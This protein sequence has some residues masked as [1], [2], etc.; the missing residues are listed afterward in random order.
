MSRLAALLSLTAAMACSSREALEQA[1]QP[2]YGGKPDADDRAVVAVVNFAGGQCSGTLIARRLV[3]TARHCV[4]DTAGKELD[5]V[6]GRTAFNPPDSPGAIFVVARTS[7]SDD[8][9]DYRAVSEIRLPEPL[10][11]DLCG[12]DVALLRLAEPS[13]GVAPLE[14]RTEPIVAVGERFAAVGY[15]LDEALPGQ[16]SG[17]RKRVDG[18]QVTCVGGGCGDSN[19][20]DNE[21]LGSRGACRGDSGGPALDGQGRVIGVVSRGAP[22][23][24]S[25]IYGDVA[26]R[27]A[28]LRQEARAAASADREPPPGW[29]CSG[30]VCESPEASSDAGP[31]ETC[32]FGHRRPPG[33]GGWSCAMAVAGSLLRRRRKPRP[34]RRRGK[35]A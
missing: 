27:A 2:V 6:C 14:P 22:Q 24:L 20:R 35:G 9:H 5:V 7:I 23:C 21:W 4:A 34:S 1:A 3:L 30:G 16:P 19:V 15:G 13:T 33:V 17:E 11:D 28:W 25:P 12:T 8:P 10:G 18:L 31:T 29:A 32:T 26:S